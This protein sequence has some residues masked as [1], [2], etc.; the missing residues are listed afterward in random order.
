M[1]FDSL[2]LMLLRLRSFKPGSEWCWIPIEV[3][4][5]F[6]DIAPIGALIK[7]FHSLTYIGIKHHSVPGLKD[8]ISDFSVFVQESYGVQ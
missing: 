4:T 8:R 7:G 6:I 5:S 3:L 2:N 1:V